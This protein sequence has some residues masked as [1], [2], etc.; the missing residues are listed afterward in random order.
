MLTR[1]TGVINKYPGTGRCHRYV[2]WQCTGS[3]FQVMPFSRFLGTWDCSHKWFPA[4]FLEH[5]FIGN[6][7][8]YGHV[9][10]Q[11]FLLE[12]LVEI[13]SGNI[14]LMDV[15][16]IRW[17]LK[18][19]T[20]PLT[21]TAK[22]TCQTG[23]L[24][25]LIGQLDWEFKKNKNLKEQNK[26]SNVNTATAWKGLSAHRLVLWWLKFEMK[27]WDDASFIKGHQLE[28]LPHSARSVA[29]MPLSSFHT[30]PLNFSLFLGARG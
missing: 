25:N 24:N 9:L 14:S 12:A 13:W 4:S 27:T 8:R 20:A 19:D 3:I 29:F 10:P 17:Q 21:K 23:W 2:W 30:L 16:P 22:L 11:L 6:I 15:L 18:C 26:N 7:R 1:S 5:F 28:P